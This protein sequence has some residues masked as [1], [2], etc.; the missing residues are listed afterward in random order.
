MEDE[1]DTEVT[2]QDLTVLL[3][4]QIR[5]YEIQTSPVNFYR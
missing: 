3:T 4:E 1:G 5:W 2:L